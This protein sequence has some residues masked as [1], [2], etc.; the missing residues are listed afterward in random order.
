MS[1][2]QI[3]DSARFRIL[4]CLVGAPLFLTWLCFADLGGY[5]SND[6][7][8]YGRP[9]KIFADEFRYQVVRQS[10]E[11]AASSAAHVF[12]GGLLSTVFGFSYRTLFLAV[13]IQLWL[14]G[15]AVT[16][17]FRRAGCGEDFSLLCAAIFLLNPLSFGHGFTFMTDGPAMAWVVFAVALFQKGLREGSDSALIAGSIAAGVAFWMRQ[18]HILIVGFPVAS[19][20]VAAIAYGERKRVIQR[21]MLAVTPALLSVLLFESGW[22]VFGDSGRVHTVFPATID[23][24]QLVIDVYG[25]TLL[26]GF[27]T[28]PLL[29]TVASTVRIQW[30][31]GH[32]FSAYA[33]AI[34]IAAAMVAMISTSGRAVLTSATGTLLQNAHLGPIFLSDFE[35]PA[36]WGD[37]GGVSWPLIVW[38]GITVAAVV[39]FGLLAGSLLAAIRQIHSDSNA[40][41]SA[42]TVGLLICACPIVVLILNVSTGVL[43]RYWLLLLPIVF[44]LIAECT[45]RGSAF[46]AH[47]AGPVIRTVGLL[48]LGLIAV[49]SIVFVHDFLTWNQ[50]RWAQTQQWLNDGLQAQDF[51]G[52]RDINAWYRS[53]EDTDTMAREG[54]SSGWWSGLATRA[55]SIGPRDG[56]HQI[57]E[58]KWSAWATGRE[59]SIL[60]LHRDAL[61]SGQQPEESTE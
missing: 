48:L 61:P 36:R 32:R 40:V 1:N 31:A 25:L 60:I 27:L 21:L 47:L 5:P 10:G 59:H 6:D 22:I 56:W 45:G 7:P 37:M 16:R 29:P 42:I 52:G 19:L 38:Q 51:D 15:M 33:S 14:A 24:R 54:D 35:N 28:L 49:M 18:T 41:D 8:F 50:T 13:I 3:R 20:L 2:L 26:I 55:L 46:A 12:F 57:S 39:N 53:A 44:C 58:L 11:L 30:Q 17:I 43:D 9:A 34:A 23:V 4:S